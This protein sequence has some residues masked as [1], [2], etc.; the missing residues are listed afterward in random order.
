MSETSV[1]AAVYAFQSGRRRAMNIK[2][3]ENAMNISHLLLIGNLR[4]QQ[5]QHANKKKINVEHF[6]A[7]ML[8]LLVMDKV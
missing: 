2:V 1:V 3:S 4:Q 7:G 6:Q 5:Q 8:K